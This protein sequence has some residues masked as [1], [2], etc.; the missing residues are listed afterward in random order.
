[1]CNDHRKRDPRECHAP[2]CS[3]TAIDGRIFC[4]ICQALLDRV[5][6]ELEAGSG[7]H[8]G[9]NGNS[10]PTVQSVDESKAASFDAGLRRR[11]ANEQPLTEA[12]L[13]TRAVRIIQL[14]Q[15]GTSDEQIVNRLCLTG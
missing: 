5:K 2:D 10:I 11:A 14:R 7:G 4:R 1:M 12:G 13:L 9:A 8:R 6:K 15:E 3:G